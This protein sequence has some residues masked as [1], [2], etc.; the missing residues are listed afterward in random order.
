MCPIALAAGP[1]SWGIDFADS[2]DNAPYSE[3]LDGIAGAGVEWL[4]LGPVGYLPGDGETVQRELEARGLASVG[5]FVFDDLHL[6]DAAGR[7]H[8]A[9]ELALDAIVATKGRLLVLIDRPDTAR[10]ATAGRAPAAARLGPGAWSAMVDTVRRI[11]EH[12]A[13][14]A[15]RTV[16]HPH[17]GSHVE[18]EDEIERLVADV[19]SDEL[20]LCLDTG[21]ALYA[22]SDPAGLIRRHA[23][24]IEHVHVKDVSAGVHARGE[25]FW[26]AV[27]AGVFCPIGDGMLD[28][29][30]VRDA[31]DAIGYDGFAT[32]EQDRRTDTA[33]SPADDLR[34]GVARLRA[35]G[36]G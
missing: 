6:A 18:F 1:V 9:A 12:A 7:V 24:R 25:D 32:V 4:E 20:G 11:G 35:A 30:G 14:R 23:D 16:F 33:G 34:R 8:E 15:V 10:A 27:A 2:P 5:T 26:S 19:P 21:H 36:I 3:V 31:L 29:A 22:G 28:I 13:D 17:A